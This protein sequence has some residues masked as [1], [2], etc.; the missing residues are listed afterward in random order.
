MLH[1][2][3]IHPSPSTPSSGHHTQKITPKQ[4]GPHRTHT[5]ARTQRHPALHACSSEAQPRSTP[6]RLGNA[7]GH[8][9][10]KRCAAGQDARGF[11]ASTKTEVAVQKHLTEKRALRAHLH[12]AARSTPRSPL[13]PGPGTMQR[14]VGCL[15]G[16]CMYVQGRLATH[17]RSNDQLD[18]IVQV[19][20]HRVRK[21]RR[22]CRHVRHGSRWSGHPLK[23]GGW[24][25]CGLMTVAWACWHKKRKNE[26]TTT[27]TLCCL[28]GQWGLKR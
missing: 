26:R 8:R 20:D 1:A 15:G 24:L 18:E 25:W 3:P 12:W 19:E 21:E 11:H 10:A 9:C 17:D 22:R 5:P 4:T 6:S 16:V 27:P 28:S 23:R 14:P 7:W 2:Q 13:Q